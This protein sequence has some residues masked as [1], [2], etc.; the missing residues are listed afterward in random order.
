VIDTLTYALNNSFTVSFLYDDK[1]RTVEIHAVGKTS[2]GD[3][4]RGF[5]VAGESS[6]P[7]PTWALYSLDKITDLSV[8][9]S[10]GPRPGYAMHDKQL[11]EIYAQLKLP[12]PEPAEIAAD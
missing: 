10:Y 9:K 7:L 6:R 4:L 2:K 3:V 1:P 8:N 5:Q 12:E 11:V